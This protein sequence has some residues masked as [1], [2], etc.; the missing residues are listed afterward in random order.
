LIFGVIPGGI[1]GILICVLLSG[2]AGGY[3]GPPPIKSVDPEHGY[4]FSKTDHGGNTN[5]LFVV[6]TFSG[7]GT[8]AAA[9]AYGVLEHLAATSIEW[10]GQS[11]RLL[12]EVDVISSVSGGS[13]TAAY[14]A[15]HRERIFKEFETR[16]LKQDAQGTLLRRSL[17][18]WNW[19]RLASPNFSTTDLLA[20]YLDETLFSGATFG[21]IA[22]RNKRP[23]VTLNATDVTTG[24]RFEFIQEQFDL[25]CSDLD[26][27]PVARAVAASSAFPLFFNTVILP[28]RAGNC[29]YQEAAWVDFSLG[30]RQLS[31]RWYFHAKAL[32]SY[33]NS[34]ARPFIF[35]TD[36]GVS[37]NLGLRSPLDTVSMQDGAWNLSR[38]LGITDVR[39]VVFIIVSAARVSEISW[40]HRRGFPSFTLLMKAAADIPVDRYSFETKELLRANLEQW[41]A[42]IRTHRQPANGSRES[43]GIDFYLVDVDFEAL[44]DA[45]ERE[46]LQRLPTRLSL[47]PTAVDRVRKSARTLLESD[48]D[49]SRLLRDI[50][51][52]SSAKP[53]DRPAQKLQ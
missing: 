31:S 14:Y 36:G 40:K 44:Q 34:D 52:E 5:S 16:F 19:P 22:A 32:R 41:S 7:G 11:R 28:N 9:L 47:P 18:P 46:Y 45:T 13:V 23:F 39:K 1:R 4:R 48:T 2:C 51:E 29:G 53:R 42:D 27:F 30:K 50:A 21:D 3:T 25:I 33:L 26:S 49:F 15:L 17:A 38:R 37:D 35:L 8:R 6:L 24:A 20:E 12:D 10:E 43:P